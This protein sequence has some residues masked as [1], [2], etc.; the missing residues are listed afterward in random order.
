MGNKSSNGNVCQSVG[1][2]DDI[3]NAAAHNLIDS[4]TKAFSNALCDLSAKNSQYENFSSVLNIQTES[5]LGMISDFIIFQISWHQLIDW[6][7]TFNASEHT[8][9]FRQGEEF[10]KTLEQKGLKKE[11]Q[12]KDQ[13]DKIFFKQTKRS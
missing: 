1:T 4:S 9:Y 10:I 2:L 8:C 3:F 11:N 5:G 6:L 12:Q 13:E 7:W